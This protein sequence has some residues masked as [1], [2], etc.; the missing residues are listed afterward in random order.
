[1]ILSVAHKFVLVR[2]RKV[3]GTS[4]EIAL[5]TICGPDDIVSPLIGVD[6]RRRQALNGRCG[7]YSSDPVWEAAYAAL[8]SQTPLDQLHRLHKPPARY[9]AHTS[10]SQICAQY[11]G[12]L[13]G[14]QVLCLARHPYARVLSALNMQRTFGAY[15]RGD[16]MRSEPQ[17]WARAFDNAVGSGALALLMNMELYRGVTGAMTMRVLRYEHL[18]DDF[19]A[20]TA[21][22][23]VCRRVALP[24]AKKGLM[25]N[26][27]NAAQILRRDQ[28]D[29]INEMFSEEF[30]VFGYPRQ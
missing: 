23:G 25:S 12:S 20:F 7:N 9:A 19:D 13:D 3:A 1:V 22:L 10:L 21:A 14:F 15:Q 16:R 27:L 11:P 17:T 29:A 2:G 4:V 30:E 6:E 28:L 8:V 5:S 18:Q 24:H 26:R